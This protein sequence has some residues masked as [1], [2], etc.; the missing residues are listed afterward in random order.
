MEKPS[1]KEPLNFLQPA[2]EVVQ[3]IYTTYVQV[4]YR[5]GC[6]FT[7]DKELVKDA[8]QDVFLNLYTNPQLISPIK[9]IK[10]YLLKSIK[11][12]ILA[13]LRSK[14]NKNYTLENIPFS[15]I[16]TPS[17][18]E[19]TIE[20]EETR[21]LKERV[22]KVFSNLTSRQCEVLYYKYV[23]ELSVHEISLLL[24]INPQSVHNILYRAVIKA[25]NILSILFILMTLLL[26]TNRKA[27][28]FILYQLEVNHKIILK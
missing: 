13:A 14:H 12:R 25:R 8:I 23:E 24:R 27:S 11:N 10:V 4:L 16:Q 22:K 19:L 28:L 18:E 17:D 15:L 21:I 6:R 1:S 9:N 7:A 2:V 5:Y 20:T 3:V 26:T